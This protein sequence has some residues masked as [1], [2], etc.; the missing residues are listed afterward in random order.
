M[1][2]P[3]VQSILAEEY[4]GGMQL[5]VCLVGNLGDLRF[6]GNNRGS[7]GVKQALQIRL[8]I[9]AV[10]CSKVDKFERLK[11]ALSRPHGK[12]HACLGAYGAFADVENHFDFDPLI[13]RRFEMQQSSGD[14]ELVQLASSLPPVFQTN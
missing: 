13:Q 3:F 14:R 5:L 7:G 10:F 1:G 12:Q 2:P 6:S 8:Q 4:S 9:T 11:I